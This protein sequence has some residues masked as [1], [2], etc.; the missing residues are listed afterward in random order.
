VKSGSRDLRNTIDTEIGSFEVW[1]TDD[2]IEIKHDGLL[3]GV[4]EYMKTSEDEDQAVADIV[5]WYVAM[6]PK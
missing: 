4:L 1:E 6:T 5:D 2:G 3:I